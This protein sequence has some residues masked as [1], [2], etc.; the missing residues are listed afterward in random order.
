MPKLERVRICVF[1]GNHGVAERGVSAYPASVTAQMVANFEAGGAAIN[2]LA[3]TFE[4][5]LVVRALDLDRPTRDFTRAPA[6]EEDELLEAVRAGMDAVDPGL[7]L[8]IGGEMGI[9]NTT[10]AAAILAALSGEPAGR[11]V[12]PGTGL[13]PEGVARKARVVAE[14]LERHRGA[15]GDP[16]EVL[17]RLG[18]REIAAL[19]GLMLGARLVRIP[20]L[21]DGYVTTAAAAV[22]HALHPEGLAHVLAGHRSAEPAHALALERLGLVPLLDLGMRLGEGSGAALALGVVRAAVACHAGMATFESAGVDR[23]VGE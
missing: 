16:L 1:A 11:M 23:A 2:Q 19:F 6:M 17:R 21:L 18:G 10:S 8:V 3:R 7:D 13:D 14:A 15:L 9:G 4:A 12:G 20:V 5:E 22:L